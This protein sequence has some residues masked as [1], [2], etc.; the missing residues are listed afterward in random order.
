MKTLYLD[1]ELMEKICHPIAVAFFDR[2][3]EPMPSFWPHDDSL[4]ESA[5]NQPRQTFDAQEL[6]PGIIDKASALFFSL[7]KNHPFP[8]GNKRLATASLLVFLY[9]NEYWLVA[10]D[11][12]LA[13]LAIKVARLS[14]PRGMTLAHQKI[15][16][17]LTAKLTKGTE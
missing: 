2:P 13:D 9:I 1:L 16:K 8:N 6:Y 10:E 5:L 7:V 11:S 15:E 4:L 14:G 12:E 3:G 17:W